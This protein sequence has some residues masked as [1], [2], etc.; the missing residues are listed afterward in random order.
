MTTHFDKIIELT[1]N[2]VANVNNMTNDEITDAFNSL[3]IRLA[4]NTATPDKAE[5]EE[6]AQEQIAKVIPKTA[7]VLS[8]LPTPQQLTDAFMSGGVD[9]FKQQVIDYAATAENIIKTSEA[10]AKANAI[11]V[12]TIV[13][14]IVR[15]DANGDVITP[16]IN[17]KHTG[18]KKAYELWPELPKDADY[19]FPVSDFK[20]HANFYDATALHDSGALRAIAI[21]QTPDDRRK[22]MYLHGE[23]GTGK[24]SL[25]FDTIYSEGQRRYVESL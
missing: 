12:T 21:C 22:H 10:T 15:Q 3:Q 13:T 5:Y 2:N 24:S 8:Q 14:K 19:L 16:A 18:F 11:P 23:S 6:N 7:K 20:R 9:A 17:A 4:G 1:N 25:V